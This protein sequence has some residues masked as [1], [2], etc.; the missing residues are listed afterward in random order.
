MYL[1][2]GKRI[3]DIVVG[4]IALPFL[5]LTTAV[6]GIFILFDDR[7]PLFY[8]GLRVGRGGK[9]FKMYK[10]RSMHLDS[11]DLCM[12]DG[13]TYN[14]ADDPRMTRV[15]ALLRKTS[16]DELPQFINVLIGNMSVVGPRPDLERETLLYEGDEGD[17]LLVKP[18][19]T[20]YAVVY[21]RNSL[22]WHERLKLDVY[23]VRNAGFALDCKIFFR[24]F[25]TIFKQEGIF[26][27][28]EP[29]DPKSAS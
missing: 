15:G 28:E 7:G 25:A 9:L 26:I 13:S 12:P 21:G 17:K 20:G 29:A 5:L 18:G 11:P 16:I 4:I 22:P 27:E 14:S 19:I 23:Y 6:V 8:N 2:F 10:F 3:C 24:T 1:R